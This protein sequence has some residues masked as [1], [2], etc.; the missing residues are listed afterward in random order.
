MESATAH[1][2]AQGGG[3]VERLAC[4]A[5]CRNTI[6]QSV[7]SSKFILDPK[8]DG[9][10]FWTLKGTAHYGRFIEIARPNRVH[11]TWGFPQHPGNRVDSHSTVTFQKQ[12][13]DTL[14]SLVH[15]G[16]PDTDEG[17]SHEKGWSYFLGISLEQFGR[18][19][20]KQYRWEEAHPHEGH[21]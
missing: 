1:E 11:H 4:F 20:R 18:G 21:R 19:S 3:S 6:N 12:G 7:D 5:F 13:E 14:M 2:R 8:V 9:L 10:F 16:L 15:S 17:R